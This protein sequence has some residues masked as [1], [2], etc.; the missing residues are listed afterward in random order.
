MKNSAPRNPLIDSRHGFSLFLLL[1]LCASFFYSRRAP[2]PTLFIHRYFYDHWLLT[3]GSGFIR[4]G[5][6]GS[7]MDLLGGWQHNLILINLLAFS[8]AAS[9]IG[10]LIRQLMALFPPRNN[11]SI[12][13]ISAVIF[14][15]LVS[16]F[17]RCMGD[18]LQLSLLLAFLSVHLMEKR[19]LPVFYQAILFAA[20]VVLSILIHEAALFIIGPFI[21]FILWR[22]PGEMA[23]QGKVAAIKWAALACYALLLSAT[24]LLIQPHGKLEGAPRERLLGHMYA[25]NIITRTQYVTGRENPFPVVLKSINDEVKGH[26]R[27]SDK[28]HREHLIVVILRVAAIPLF[29]CTMFYLMCAYQRSALYAELWRNFVYCFLSSLALS[30]PLYFVA[31]D[32][33][34]FSL[35][36]L[37]ASLYLSCKRHIPSLAAAAGSAPPLNPVPLQNADV[38]KECAAAF[39]STAFRKLLCLA[40][41]IFITFPVPTNY[42]IDGLGGQFFLWIGLPVYF[43]FRLFDP[44]LA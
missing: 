41:L 38:G 7:L 39:S 1:L 6:L 20:A 31:H 16:N 18:P 37:A 36:T 30:L 28:I 27:F 3:Y 10:L 2:E 40:M 12:I 14:S 4:R 34:R 42:T 33:G 25:H 26:N 15:P 29:I 11:L 9:I 35:Y 13:F 21:F 19:S 32:W 24:V 22:S 43:L 5:L 44:E 23:A 17:F 8:A